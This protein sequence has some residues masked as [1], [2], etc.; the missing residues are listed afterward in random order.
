[1]VTAAAAAVKPAAAAEKVA[2]VEAT[3]ATVKE[4]VMS[5]PDPPKETV[6][7][8]SSAQPKRP[9]WTPEN[10]L[11]AHLIFDFAGAL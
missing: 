3:A 5:H 4:A 7:K 8:W 9:R 6:P 10:V 2:P 1:M 11:G